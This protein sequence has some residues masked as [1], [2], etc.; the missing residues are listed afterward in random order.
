MR[1]KI[2]LRGAHGEIR[3]REFAAEEEL[4]RR[5]RKIGV[6]DCSI[7][8]TLRGLPVYRGLI[9]PMPDKDDTARYETPEVFEELTKI[10]SAPR[11]KRKRKPVQSE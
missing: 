11:R 2:A 4:S 6:E 8:L 7:D 10:W 1:F 3:T 5:Y 9:G